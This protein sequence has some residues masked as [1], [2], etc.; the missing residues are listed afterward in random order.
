MDKIS[1]RGLEIFAY[2]GVMQEE[3]EN[4]QKFYVDATL[5]CDTKTAGM[6]DDLE[7]TVNY[8]AVCQFIDKFLKENRFDLIEAA[9]EQTVRSLLQY[10]PKIRQIEFTINK[11]S[12]P[13]GLPFENVAVSI[14]RKW[15]KVFL[16]I[17]S[18]IGDKEAYLNQA[19]E[20]FYDDEC[21]R[22]I[23]VSKYV[24]TKPYG[25]VEQDNFLNGCIEIETLYEP[26]QLLEV[27][28]Q[29]ES[30]A[31]RTR[32]VH[33]GPRTLDIDIVLY[34]NDIIYEQNLIIPHKEMHKRAFV[35]VPLAE[36]APY[37][38]HPVLNK[39]VSVLLEEL[40]DEEKESAGMSKCA[41]CSGCK[42]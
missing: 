32:E 17:G 22:V 12:A 1:I 7:D 9:A 37:A 26:E 24:E 5:F 38:Y 42:R 40:D 30:E 23:N 41:G 3:K 2:H 15:H 8:A 31:N 39:S 35:L 16:S 6:S 14:F 13:I 20:S 28:H 27:I 11:P 18:N 36:I 21:C 34:D 25:P 10:M 29:I 19:L 33:W 4:G